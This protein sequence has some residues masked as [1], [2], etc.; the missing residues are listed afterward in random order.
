[1]ILGLE[2]GMLIAGLIGLFSGKLSLSKKLVVKGAA[3]RV[4]GLVLLLPLPLAFGMGFYIGM[5]EASKGRRF[6]AKEWQGTLTLIEGGLVLG[7]GVVS[8][9]IALVASSSPES[10]RRRDMDEISEDSDL[11]PPRLPESP[12]PPPE[13][14]ERATSPKTTSVACPAC[15]KLL[16][17]PETSPGR[18]FRCP[19]CREMFS[20]TAPAAPAEDALPFLEPV[21]PIR[22]PE[23][24]SIQSQPVRKPAP[25][26]G[27]P[28]RSK[29][30]RDPFPDQ[31]APRPRQDNRLV[32]I[33]AVLLGAVLLVGGAIG[34]VLLQ[35]S[36]RDQQMAERPAGEAVRWAPV[37]PQ[38]PPPIP[39][40]PRDEREPRE[41]PV[42]RPGPEPVRPA[43]IPPRQPDP[44]PIPRVELPP[45]PDPVEIRP[46]PIRKE[47]SCKLPGTISS[48]RVGGGGRFLVLYFSS[49]NKLGVFDANE[50]R[51]V[52]YITA[53]GSNVQFAAGM[54]KL[55][56]LVPK[57]KNIY[58]YNLLNGREESAKKVDLPDGNIE[59]FCMGHASAGPLLI[60][61]ARH[62]ARLYDIDRFGEIPL[63]SERSDRR[64]GLTTRT[65]RNGYYWAGAT[66]RVFGHTGN[67]GMPNGVKTIVLTNG[68][69]EEYYAHIATWF[70]V[71]G[72]DD[73]HVYAGG[74][75]V[76]SERVTPVSDAVYTMGLDGSGFASHLYL[77]AHHGPYY[78]HA[79][80]FNAPRPIGPKIPAGTVRIF[81]F[82]NKQPITTLHR[83]AV[84]KYDDWKALRNLGIEHS[85]HLIPRANLLAIV[86]ATCNELRLYP[87]NLTGRAG[88]VLQPPAVVTPAPVP[89]VDG[90]RFRDHKDFVEDIKTGLLWQKDGSASG[91]LNFS[92]A[93]EYAEGLN[94]GE[95]TGWRVPTPEELAAI[96]PAVDPPFTNTKYNKNRYHQGSGEWNW[97]WT[98]QRNSRKADYA[99]A[100]R[101]S[102]SGGQNVCNASRFF[103]Y[104]RCV[105]DPVKKK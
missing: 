101:W 10:E 37:Q 99:Y 50:A 27:E 82:G 58:R 88:K 49:L 63:P 54:T 69:V 23:R 68:K 19:G 30:D 98:S 65:L 74:H 55:V 80:T 46:A 61:V 102:A 16:L 13:P 52:R 48:L 11:V 1:M 9:L 14:R 20:P 31:K 2:I 93:L 24:G 8:I 92:Q 6:D 40:K 84:C 39:E 77:P 95:L 75:G 60:G 86:P 5:E 38:V 28:R 91:K 90:G 73:Q 26:M 4:A 94:L 21:E 79:Q 12:A 36:G 47:T 89:P 104:V 51:V 35:R 34:I 81:T 62:D 64:F 59:A 32:F 42:I 83:T 15:G 3:A 53:P 66:G 67:Y 45:L 33:A 17:L 100:Y 76:I 22:A 97:Y 18:K 72:P 25:L 96:F 43:V 103:F 29:P 7:C 78:L 70:V 56:V 87:V 105:H 57:S 85:I 71:P 44:P 41:P